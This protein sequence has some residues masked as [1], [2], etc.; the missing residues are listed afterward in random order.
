MPSTEFTYLV[1]NI[2]YIIFYHFEIKI[3]QNY[4]PWI[5]GLCCKHDDILEIYDFSN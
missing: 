3:K 2:Q 5:F 4:W 1:N